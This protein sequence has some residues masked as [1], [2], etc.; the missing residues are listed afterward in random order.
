[1]TKKTIIVAAVLLL[2]AVLFVGAGAAEN[3]VPVT[4]AEELKT[5]F[6]S[7]ADGSTIQLLN[8][9]SLT[10]KL[11]ISLS[12]KSVTLDLN[13]K[14][15]AGRLNLKSGTL[16][17]SGPGKITNTAQP[18]NVYGSDTSTA[19]RYSVLTI[20]SGVVVE[21]EDNTIC[22]FGTELTT[23][24]YGAVI[25]VNG[26]VRATGSDSTS[27][28]IFVSGNLGKTGGTND[29]VVSNIINLKNGCEVNGNSIP[30]VV[31]NGAAT[32]NVENGA[33]ISG[34]DGITVKG[35]HLVVN[36]GTIV[37]TGAK[38]TDD[39]VV[40]QN[41]G[42]ETS[43]SAITISS[44]YNVPQSSPINVEI[45][46]G[47][48]TSSNNHAVYTA[49]S[50]PSGGE[51][52]AFSAVSLAISGGDFTGAK[53]ED[54]VVVDTKLEGETS[55]V[56]DKFISGGNFVAS[57]PAAK[58]KLESYMKSSS[59]AV[60]NV[61]QQ[62]LLTL[63]EPES[64]ILLIPA[65]FD[66]VSDTTVDGYKYI[67][68]STPAGVMNVHI[69]AGKAV[70]VSVKSTNDWKLS[71]T[72]DYEG[73]YGTKGTKTAA[74][75]SSTVPFLEVQNGEEKTDGMWFGIASST[76]VNA[77]VHTDTLTFSAVIDNPTTS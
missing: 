76:T 38:P 4:T 45:K 29:M 1:M 25:D 2:A 75:T 3:P 46:G 32:V 28:A 33:S 66:F 65:S 42:A 64:Y 19:I 41:N 49:H 39:K 6:T 40:A 61:G 14:T 68:N 70:K 55:Y 54:A 16:T 11:E 23:N 77:G 51:A 47:T 57:S 53:G 59:S 24:G 48:L 10:D 71:G 27:G 74:M 44:N 15:L 12:G 20:G 36:G 56:E 9:I 62:T 58:A 72:I 8:G 17:I 21:A 69:A 5:A 67:A 18:L 37:A 7:A 22:L 26:I 35:G 31:L 43:G 60:I 30:A 63:S 52:K 34:H 13:G 50:T 73:F